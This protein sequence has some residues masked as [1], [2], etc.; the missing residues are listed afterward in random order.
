MDSF[1]K[2]L[3]II[4][5]GWKDTVKK[6]RL[7]SSDKEWVERVMQPVE[8]MKYAPWFVKRVVVPGMANSLD[9]EHPLVQGVNVHAF[10]EKLG[11]LFSLFKKYENQHHQDINAFQNLT[12]FLD[13]LKPI[14]EKEKVLDENVKVL[15]EVLKNIDI[16]S[17]TPI[18]AMKKLI[19][20]NEKMKRFEL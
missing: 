17:L 12:E 9:F 3:T 18:E 19:E 5:E 4:E 15:V 8:S 14:V 2:Y 6:Y 10:D 13:F 11:H 7:S 20:I 16:N 1:V